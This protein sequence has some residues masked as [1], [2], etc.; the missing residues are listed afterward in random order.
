MML[1]VCMFYSSVRKGAERESEL[2]VFI[3]AL[4]EIPTVHAKYIGFIVTK[5]PLSMGLLFDF[6]PYSQ[7]C[8]KSYP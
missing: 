5:Y 1:T 6:Y 3:R 2:F 4:D 7:V 8:M